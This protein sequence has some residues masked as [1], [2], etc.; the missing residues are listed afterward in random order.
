MKFKIEIRDV[1]MREQASTQFGTQPKA[2][3]TED[4][5]SQRQRCIKNNEKFA[6]F[7]LESD[8]GQRQRTNYFMH[9]GF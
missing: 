5:R 4:N 9:S 7:E 1:R 2:Q 6:I 3:Q 8:V